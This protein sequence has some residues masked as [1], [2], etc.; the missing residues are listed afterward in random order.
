M[1][2]NVVH[3]EWVRLWSSNIF[4]QK[5]TIW[6]KE[7]F[8]VVT[9]SEVGLLNQ[10]YDFYFRKGSKYLC[11]HFTLLYFFRIQN[12]NFLRA[13]RPAPLKNSWRQPSSYRPKNCMLG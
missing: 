8:A 9:F 1:L 11:R 12:L 7:Y 2:K 10:D 13:H 6:L 4:F 5:K 3:T